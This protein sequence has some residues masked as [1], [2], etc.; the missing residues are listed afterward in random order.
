M[1]K[2]DGSDVS[3][4]EWIQ[5]VFPGVDNLGHW[6]KTAPGADYAAFFSGEFML[7]VAKKEGGQDQAYSDARYRKTGSGTF[8]RS[9]KNDAGQ[10]EEIDVKKSSRSYV[11]NDYK[12]MRDSAGEAFHKRSDLMKYIHKK[13]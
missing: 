3:T 13:K 7:D 12:G 5:G 10:L 9:E 2:A 11:Y 8:H 1:S 6:E 4:N